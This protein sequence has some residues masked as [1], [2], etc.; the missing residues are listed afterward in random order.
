MNN[1]FKILVLGVLLAGSCSG[2]KTV[3]D[4]PV[5]GY[6]V[7]NAY[8]HD[9]GGFTQ[10]LVYDDGFLYEGTGGY[11]KSTLRR[12][13]LESGIV[14]VKRR[15]DDAYFGEGITICGDRIIQLTWRSGKG[16]VYDKESFK[17]AGEFSYK[18][19]GWG[20]TYDGER[21]ILSDGSSML[22]FLDAETF[23]ELG[24]VEV[25]DGNGPAGRLNELEY[26]KGR[27]FANV[28]GTERIAIIEPGSGRVEGWIELEGIL[29]DAD[30]RGVDVLNGIAYDA[31]GQRLF[32]TGKLWPKLF[33]I[34]VVWED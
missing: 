34:E 20:I 4:A 15:L 13:K 9:R 25:Y 6:R 18:T 3:D 19:E 21:L 33:E 32:V 14:S 10:G 12:V 30:S 22:Y 5:Y 26:V 16:F 27:I 24:R 2:R 8:K 31:V 11:G 23:E 29:S 1:C 17:L 28:W 7:V